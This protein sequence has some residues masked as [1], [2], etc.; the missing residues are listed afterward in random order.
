MVSPHPQTTSELASMAGD[1]PVDID[2]L[3]REHARYV[4]GLAFRL[5]GSH[6]IDDIVQEVFLAAHRGFRRLRDPNAER[7]WLRTV[8]VRKVRRA[9][10]LRRAR[11]LL[12]RSEAVPELDELAQQDG[13]SPAELALLQQVFAVLH[14]MPAKLRLPWALRHLEGLTLPE[15]AESCQCSLATIKRRLHDSQQRIER[16]MGPP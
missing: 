15:I 8:T 6:D 3:F 1:D 9:I 12:F 16:E 14:R 13:A 2:R 10:K 5:S 4:A 11:A 7:A